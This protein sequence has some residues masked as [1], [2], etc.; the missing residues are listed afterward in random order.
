MLLVIIMLNIV[1]YLVFGLKIY[2]IFFDFIFLQFCE[3]FRIFELGFYIVRF[4]GILEVLNE[5][6]VIDLDLYIISELYYMFCTLGVF[7]VYCFIWY[8]LL[9]LFVRGG[10]GNLERVNVV[11]QIICLE[12]CRLKL[13]FL[14]FRQYVF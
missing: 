9:V 13:G 4:K 3:L 1:V 10:N 5:S 12:S 2:D 8:L 6:L 14:I 11:V 7:Y